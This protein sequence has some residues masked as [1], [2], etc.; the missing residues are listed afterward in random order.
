MSCV[1]HENQVDIVGVWI[2][3]N[4]AAIDDDVGHQPR[5]PRLPDKC[6]ELILHLWPAVGCLKCAKAFTHLIERAIMNSG[7]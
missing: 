5:C 6:L 7:R 2:G 3:G 4:E 1:E